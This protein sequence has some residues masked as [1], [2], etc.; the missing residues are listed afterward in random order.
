MATEE[1][2]HFKRYKRRCRSNLLTKGKTFNAETV[3]YSAEGVG[4]VVDDDPPVSERAVIDIDV[5][6][7]NVRTNGQI[8]WIK[9][10]PS[11]VRVGV[12]K[13][14]PLSGLL[15]DYRIADILLD[16]QRSGKTGVLMVKS[17]S[18]L[19]RIYV[20]NGEMTFSASNRDVDRLGD[21]LLREGKIN[22]EQYNHS[23]DILKKTGKRQGTI[24]VELGY[25]KPQELVRAVQHQV[26]EI[27]LSLFDLEQGKFEFKEGPFPTDEVITLKLSAAN[28]IYRG[29]KRINSIA[30]IRDETPAVD[31]IL[32]LSHDPLNLFQSITLDEIGKNVLSYI[33]GKTPIKDILFLLPVS[34]LETLKTI[35]A[36]LSIKIIEVKEEGE[37]PVE[38]VTLEDIIKE[39][40]RNVSGEVI[41]R[42][43]DIYSGY[44]SL[45]YYEILGIKKWA[46]QDAI[47]RAYY[48]TAKEF[49]PDRY[50][51]LESDKLKDKLNTIF[52]FVTAAYTTLSNPEKR[53]QY[54][55]QLFHK[56]ER[57]LSNDELAKLKFD[58]GKTELARQNFAQA[59]EL[60]GQAVYLNSSVA[61]YHYYYGLA[62][63]KLNRLKEAARAIER[64]SKIEPSNANYLDEAGH[65]YLKLGLSQRAKGNF[66]KALR[67]SPSHK[68]AEEGMKDL[69]E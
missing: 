49:H 27:I 16:L 34:E 50:F 17:D 26:E 43:E 41:D 59:L 19:K 3:D 33:G 20:K 47:K 2:R 36:L 52:S 57:T 51:C 68:R 40:E 64:A 15:K 11:G 42:I 24:L 31:A 37:S 58:E 39:P 67:L 6:D 18:I 60:F 63:G 30:R 45:G 48:R 32:R 23:V 46:T 9:R 10:I 62:L 12:K 8:V 4:A 54:D 65:I 13:L 35:Y 61:R 29:I 53:K 21:I 56:P 7:L 1:K 69:K 28:L 5:P 55:K 14:G 66:E 44:E 25:L 22:L 38:G